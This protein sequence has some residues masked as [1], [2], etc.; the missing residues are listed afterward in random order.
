MRKPADRPQAHHRRRR[1]HGDEGILDLAVL[2]I[3]RG[4]DRARG[5]RLG[6][7]LVEGLQGD[8]HDSGVRTV[9]EPVDA[10]AGECHRT[11]DAR[12]LQGDLTHAANHCLGT[13]ERCGIGQLC[14]THEVLLVLRGNEAQVGV[15]AKPTTV[16]AIKPP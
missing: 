15:R 12:L 7:A 8:E 13:I 9:R 2:L 10:Q 1:E 4:C 3:E 6:F 5:Q 16:S 14:E 11:L